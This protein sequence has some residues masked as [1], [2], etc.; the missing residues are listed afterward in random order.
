VLDNGKMRAISAK[1]IDPLAR[2][3]LKFGVT[4]D[5][6]T[7]LFNNEQRVLITL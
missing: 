5:E 7:I 3:L 1:S 6:V 4:P 2:R